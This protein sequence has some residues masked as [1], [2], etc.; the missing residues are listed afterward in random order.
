M[1]LYDSSMHKL[2]GLGRP[3]KRTSGGSATLVFKER[4]IA[5][6]LINN[7]IVTE[8]A[9]RK[10]PSG[11]LW[12][13]GWWNVKPRTVTSGFLTPSHRPPD[14]EEQKQVKTIAFDLQVDPEN[15]GHQFHRIAAWSSLS[16]LLSASLPF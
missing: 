4:Q 7:G 6:S 10:R 8:R 9:S 3:L 15:P 16:M 11:G 5:K 2:R 12:P 14:L 13:A 1:T